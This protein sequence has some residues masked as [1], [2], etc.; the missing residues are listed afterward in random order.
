MRPLPTAAMPMTR[1]R[2]ATDHSCA[3]SSSSGPTALT[4]AERPRPSP[5]ARPVRRR[6]PRRAVSGPAKTMPTWRRSA[7]GPRAAAAA[8]PRVVRVEAR[9]IDVG[10]IDVIS[11]VSES[12]RREREPTLRARLVRP[13][14]L[15]SRETPRPS[16]AAH[17]KIFPI[18]RYTTRG[19]SADARRAPASDPERAR[20]RHLDTRWRWRRSRSSRASASR[21][22][23]ARRE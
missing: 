23:A 19:H 17:C 20:R 1:P 15:C 6:A 8:G 18:L 22:R 21:S 5:R 3:A 7:R 9:A 10:A 11:P 2:P 12:T 4:T 13:S 14:R 16:L